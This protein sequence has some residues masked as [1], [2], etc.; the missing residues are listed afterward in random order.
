MSSAQ[1]ALRQP[2]FDLSARLAGWLTLARI[3]NSPTVAS[4]VL[5]GAAVAGAVEPSGSLA[6][7]VVAM[8]AFYTAGMLLNDVC[9]YRWDLSHR[10][11]RPLVVGVVSRSA[12]IAATIGLFGFGGVLLWLVG[13]RALLSG[14]VLLALIVAYDVWHKSNPLSPLVMAACRVMV[15]VVAFSAFAWPPTLN[16]VLAGGALVVY[17]VG[18]TAIAKSE[19]RPTVG[20]YW[21][22]AFCFAPAAYFVAEL[23]SLAPILA[24]AHAG[25]VF[26]SI[27]LVYRKRDRRI[28]PAIAQLIA[29]ISLV[30]AMVLAA[31]N[32]PPPIIG[33]AVLAFGLTLLLQHYVEGT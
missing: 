33:L 24:I 2:R 21:P 14:G 11:D 5:A 30:D 27:R 16:L 17:L 23:R 6:L 3:S 15:Y 29:G 9:D 26:S 28:G 22:A 13:P 31:N 10:P 25:W 20:G 18:L 4:N 12:V 19:A 7:L 32:A 1:S 8:V